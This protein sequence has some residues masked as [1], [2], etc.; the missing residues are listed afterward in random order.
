MRTFA[1]CVA[2]LAA[3]IAFAQD[4]AVAVVKKAI[5]AHGGADALNK[6]KI[7]RAKTKGTMNVAGVGDVEFV[8]T[9]FYSLPD[10]FKLEMAAEIRGLKL[11]AMQMVNGK[12]VKVKTVLGSIEQPAEA[13]AKEETQ[14][15]LLL[16]EITTLTPLVEG[17]KYT[18][19]SD[20]DADIEGKANAVVVVSGNGLR[21]DVKLFF[22]KATGQLAKTERKGL[23]A[24]EK[25]IIEVKEESFLGEFKKTDAVLL[26]TRVIVKHDG[27][28]FMDVTVVEMKLLEKIDPSEFAEK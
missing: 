3:P 23:A 4:A 26:P 28:K 25:G 17:K 8:S 12:D 24:T 13:K 16:Q 10:K 6:S 22:N 7:A 21:G 2:L 27:K 9:S 18:I 5:E 19:K 15:A 20:A 1:V 14:Q 11:T